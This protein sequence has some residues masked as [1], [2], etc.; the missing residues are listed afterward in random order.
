MS[1][2]NVSLVIVLTAGSSVLLLAALLFLAM[3]VAEIMKWTRIYPEFRDW[4]IYRSQF[5][6]YMDEKHPDRQWLTRRDR[7]RWLKKQGRTDG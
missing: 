1:V 5:V 2:E 6:R 3:S 4:I 7:R